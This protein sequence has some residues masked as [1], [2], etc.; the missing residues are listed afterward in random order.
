MS[1]NKLTIEFSDE[2]KRWLVRNSEGELIDGYETDVEAFADYP[3]LAPTK[4]KNTAAEL[5]MAIET[6]IELNNNNE[7]IDGAISYLKIILNKAR[8]A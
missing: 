8:G 1:K 5:Y 6:I 2:D 4:F 7:S 3:Q